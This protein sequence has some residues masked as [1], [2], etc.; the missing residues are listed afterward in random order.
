MQYFL[1]SLFFRTL[2]CSGEARAC[3]ARPIRTRLSLSNPSRTCKVAQLEAGG[4]CS[5]MLYYRCGTGCSREEAVYELPAPV[6]GFSRSSGP[7]ESGRS[8]VRRCKAS[9]RCF[10]ALNTASTEPR[11]SEGGSRRGRSGKSARRTSPMV[12]S[13][14]TPCVLPFSASIA[15]VVPVL[16]SSYEAGTRRTGICGRAGVVRER[17]RPSKL[18]ERGKGRAAHLE[19]A[20]LAQ[21]LPANAARAH[22]AVDVAA[23]GFSVSMA[24]LVRDCVRPEGSEG[25]VD[26]R[27]DGEA[28]EALCPARDGLDDGGALG[29]D[30]A[31]Y[32][33]EGR[34]AR[35][36]GPRSGAG[37]EGE[38]GAAATRSALGR[39]SHRSQEGAG[40]RAGAHRSSRTRRW[41]P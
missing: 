34:E 29:A 4:T 5:R 21:D 14:T 35:A 32:R 12:V 8:C 6:R 26:A 36:G 9:Q 37:D 30:G 13:T 17:Q 31:A 22:H 11:L 20:E 2:A 23:S 25:A 27:R 28:D 3:A 39:T 41:R 7:N 38:G 1:L 10:C 24:L 15:V 18:K 19:R 16:P 40:W 33:G